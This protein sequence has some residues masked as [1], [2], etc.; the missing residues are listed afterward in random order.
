MTDTHTSSEAKWLSSEKLQLLNYLLEEENIQIASRDKISPVANH[1]DAPLTFAQERLWFLE[2]LKPDTALYNQFFGIRLIGHL[3]IAALERSLNEIIQRHEILRT[4]ITIVDGQPK[5]HISSAQPFALTIEDVQESQGSQREQEIRQRAMEEAR[6]SFNLTQGPLMRIRLL[7]VTPREHV[8]LLTIHH[9]AFDGWS[10]G[11]FIRELIE[12]Y[13]AYAAGQKPSLPRLSIQYADFALWQRQWLQGEVLDTQMAYWKQKLGDNPSILAFPTDHPRLAVQTFQGAVES[14]TFSKSLTEALK[15]LGLQEGLTLFMTLLAAFQTLLTRMAEQEDIIVGTRVAGRDRV[16]TEGLIGCFLNAL[17]LRTDMSGNPTFREIMHRV[18][19]VTLGA[20]SHQDLPFEKVVE[21]L[22]LKRDTNRQPLFQVMFVLQT[23]SYPTLELPDLLISPL[24]TEREMARYDLDCSMK[25]G[26]DGSLRCS[27]TYNTHLFQPATI[28]NI[29]SRFQV[30]LEA[31]CANADLPFWNLPLLTQ[32]ERQQIETWNTTPGYAFD[33]TSLHRLFEDKAAKIPHAVALMCAEQALTYQ[34]LNKYANQLAH[35]LC[36]LGVAPEVRVGVCMKRSPRML[37][38][39]LAILKAGGVYVPLDPAYPSAHLSSILS[40][41]EASV[42][43]TDQEALPCLPPHSAATIC[44]DTAW[45]TLAGESDKN[46]ANSSVLD[47]AVYIM[48]TSG[49]TGRPKGVIVPQRQVLN[50]FAWMWRTYPFKENER[51]C[52]RTTATF[53]PSIWEM[54]GPLL[55]GVPVV[56]VQDTVVKDPRLLAQTLAMHS[57]TRIVIVPSLLEGILNTGLDLQHLLAHL[58]LWSIGGEMLSVKLA[59]RFQ[60]QL[61]HTTLINQYGATEMSDVVYCDT[62]SQYQHCT[63]VPSGRP[64]MNTRV[65]LQ[66]SHWQLQS[67]GLPGELYVAG[68]GV[69]RGYLNRPDLTAERFI[70]DPFST[71]PGA[72]LYN[73]GDVARYLPDGA[74]ELLGRRDHQVKIRGFRVEVE[75]IEAVLREHPQIQQAAV[76]IRETER[77]QGDRRLAAYVVPVA[78]E[79]LSPTMLRDFMKKR[80]PEYMRPSDFMIL[81][82]LPKTSNGK[83]D[84]RALLEMGTSLPDRDAPITK[85]QTEIERIIA[86]IWQDVLQVQEI[87]VHSNFFDLG[88]HSL[89]SVEVRNKLQEILQ[90]EVTL[91]ELFEHP[92]ISSLA[93]HL[94]PQQQE[95]RLPEQVQEEAD[96]QRASRKRRKQFR[97][98]AERHEKVQ[99]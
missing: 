58:K 14:I 70:P 29:L 5:Q 55:Q 74:I 4:T 73:M 21:S 6:Q 10:R 39:L 22:R 96:A 25:E 97:Q 27:L 57:I 3:H 87:S 89:L 88:G 75:G 59:Q 67:I 40:D 15:S 8:L 18:R 17:A 34:T 64:I 31:V 46:V 49:S 60:E 65:Y 16:E 78:G 20:F 11:I 72:R 33:D 63:N 41:C 23:A 85:P 61:P 62:W 12:L 54:L 38:S 9:I 81:D 94:A 37:I 48:F 44:L 36:T 68:P 30:L 66:D 56:I 80:L 47:N 83:I 42:V 32:R 19:E 84:R 1:Q 2:Q 45:E 99:E 51:V 13:K 43:I 35:R 82:V 95:Q 79:A 50:R 90:R 7:R 91:I 71:E 69:P 53:T 52:Q 76:V 86:Q 92:T 77:G 93:H 98:M 26:D 24:E 28:Q